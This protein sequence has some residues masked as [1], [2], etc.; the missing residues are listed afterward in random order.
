ME[1]Q[2]AAKEILDEKYETAADG[3]LWS[4]EEEAVVRRR[5]DWRL[6]PL[7][8]VLY[9]LCFIDRNARIQGMQKDLNLVGF[10]FNWALTVF[11]IPYL[12]VEIPSN[13][14][15]KRIGPKIYIP[16]LI[17]TFGIVSMG[18]AFVKSFQGLCVARTFLGLVEGGTMP[19]IAFFMSCFYKRGELLFRIGI[20]VSASSLAGAF[21]GL[22]ATA[23]SRI[24]EW[25][26]KGSEVH[27]W[28]NIFFFE[29]IVTVGFGVLGYFL[30]PGNPQN[31]MFLSERQRW[32]AAERIRI[33]HKE[34]TS[35]R[36]E[37]WHVKRAIFN[38]NNLICCLGFF[39]CNITVQSFSLFL[40]TILSA[41]GWKATK[42]QL[43]T[44]PP[45]AVACCFSI[46]IAWLSDH[47]RKRGLFILVCTT[48]TLTGYS[49]LVS[50]EKANIKY[51]GVFFAA[52]GAFPLGPAFLSWG[53]NNAAGPSIRAVTGGY[54]VSVGTAG[55]ILATW[56]YVPTDGPKY[57]RGHSINLGAEICVALVSL[58]GIF[59]ARWENALRDRG[60]RDSLVVGLTEEQVQKLGY[61]HPDFRY[62]E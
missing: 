53:L 15:L 3:E 1:G 21:G 37:L 42:A 22:L 44:V 41:L 18:T 11:Y 38:I 8:T 12:L 4:V 13:I 51:M 36:T 26:V 31:C 24:P 61:R 2:N 29:G 58:L 56:T 40:P 32:I 19:G 17:I 45:Y 34:L 62:I 54:I 48:L 16:A 9:L 33:E 5:L 59:Y 52:S 35:E 39:F 6:L 47:H 43:L 30:M 50:V 14:L 25:G 10:R 20:F 57:I 28:R 49:I 23:L 7:L 27:T 55:A 60:G 46:F